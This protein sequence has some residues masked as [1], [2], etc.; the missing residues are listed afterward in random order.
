MIWRQ[1]KKKDWETEKKRGKEKNKTRNK[2]GTNQRK[3]NKKKKQRMANSIERQNRRKD[4]TH[5]E[6]TKPNMDHA[7]RPVGRWAIILGKRVQEPAEEEGKSKKTQRL[8]TRTSRDGADPED[9][10][11]P[12]DVEYADAAQLFIEKDTHGQMCERLGNYDIS[13]ETRELKIQWINVLIVHLGREH[14]EEMPPPFGQ[15]KFSQ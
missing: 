3:Q 7:Y 10:I 4:Q 5:Q 13:A 1:R 12:D 8:R 6:E 11:I 15:I 2:N 14:K 9:Y